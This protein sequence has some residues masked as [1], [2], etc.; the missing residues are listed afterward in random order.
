MDGMSHFDARETFP[1][2]VNATYSL[3]LQGRAYWADYFMN[4]HR[5]PLQNAVRMAKLTVQNAAY[6]I[7]TGPMTSFMFLK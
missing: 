2:A 3:L 7:F 1:G 4:S 5:E 6:M